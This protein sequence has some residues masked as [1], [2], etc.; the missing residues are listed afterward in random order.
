M[1]RVW[2][3]TT[4]NSYIP[5][6]DALYNLYSNQFHSGS[7]NEQTQARLPAHMQLFIQ[8]SGRKWHYMIEASSPVHVLYQLT[9]LECDS[10]Q[11]Y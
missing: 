11:Y 7:S 3:N 6:Q 5:Q 9:D 8:R 2:R 10:E 4:T 1:L